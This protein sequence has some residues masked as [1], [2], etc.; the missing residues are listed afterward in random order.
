M[1]DCTWRIGSTWHPNHD[2]KPTVGHNG[3]DVRKPI[4]WK[5]ESSHVDNTAQSGTTLRRGE[6]SC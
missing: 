6:T 5:S 4:C 3:Q 1:K 2:D